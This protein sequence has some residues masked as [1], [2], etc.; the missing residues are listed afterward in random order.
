[1][2]TPICKSLVACDGSNLVAERIEI[3][4]C[5]KCAKAIAKRNKAPKPLKGLKVLR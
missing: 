4:I 5:G 2:R 3:G 1:M